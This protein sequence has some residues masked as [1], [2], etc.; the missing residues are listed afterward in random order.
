MWILNVLLN[1]NILMPVPISWKQRTT[2]PSLLPISEDT[3]H[4]VLSD[5]RH[6]SRWD[7]LL[8]L[9]PSYIFISA[10][11]SAGHCLQMKFGS[12]LEHA[13]TLSLG[14]LV[15]LVFSFSIFC[16]PH[17]KYKVRYDTEL[18]KN[19]YFKWCSAG[20]TNVQCI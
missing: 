15:L 14:S 1:S 8:I 9:L 10:L 5:A 7:P 16:C 4:E 18:K 6:C 17:E 3:S 20:I 19:E 12:C 13:V 11:Y 2:Q